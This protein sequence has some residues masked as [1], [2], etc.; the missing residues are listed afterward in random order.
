MWHVGSFFSPTR[1]G[2]PCPCIG[3]LESNYW[4]IGKSHISLWLM[5]SSTDG[6]LGF[7][8]LVFMNISTSI[9]VDMISFSLAIYPG[10]SHAGSCGNY[11]SLFEELPTVFQSGSTL[12]FPPAVNEG[13]ISPQSHSLTNACFYLSFLL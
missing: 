4:T 6:H 7:H 12:T 9:C 2:T 1:D 3:S 11:I 5:Q 8:I 10:L 13:L